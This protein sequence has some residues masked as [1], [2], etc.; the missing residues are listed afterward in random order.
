MSANFE[1]RRLTTPQDL[2]QAAA[3]EFIHSANE[4]ITQRKRFIVALSGGSTPKGLYTLLAAN[5]S[6]SL[7]W[8]RMFFFFGDE[9]HVPPDHPE[10]NYRMASETLFSKAPI[11]PANIFRVPA[12]NPDASAAAEEY[13]KNMRDFFSSPPG[14]FPSFDLILLGLGPDGHTASLF[15]ETLALQE[16]SRLVVANWV[17][18]FKTSR[19]TFTLP[20]LNAARCVA[21]LVSGTEK[22]PAL[23][24]VLEGK[25]PG[26]KYPA[27]LVQPSD[28]KLI[29]FVDR[30]AASELSAAA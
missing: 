20:L 27:K 12:E 17:D 29:W 3:E 28:G 14:E 2:F 21:F 26:E 23:H 19:I 22:A 6:S 15:P 4:A 16:K 10:S 18:K 11:P 5:A 30:A 24:E 7:P 1:L 13:E 25:A 9:R 8:D